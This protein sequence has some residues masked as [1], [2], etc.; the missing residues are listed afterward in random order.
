MALAAFLSAVFT[1]LNPIRTTYH[2]EAPQD[3]ARPFFVL[4][5]LPGPVAYCFG[6]SAIEQPR[7]QISQ[8]YDWTGQSE[9]A[10]TDN[11]AIIAA[12]DR[13]TLTADGIMMQRINQPAI[14]VLGGGP[15]STGPRVLQMRQDWKFEYLSS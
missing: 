4:Q 12:L 14:Q 2:S 1:L 15:G 9:Q 13:Q 11:V 10:V 6:T 5:P 8:Y 3:A 7:L